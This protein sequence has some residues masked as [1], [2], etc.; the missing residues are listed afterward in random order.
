MVI[1]D[2]VSRTTGGFDVPVSFASV[3][4]T[5]G[6]VAAKAPVRSFERVDP[7]MTW[8]K[9]RDDMDRQ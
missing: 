3:G 7:S 2:E 6:A 4:A 9:V 5:V 1:M 8:N